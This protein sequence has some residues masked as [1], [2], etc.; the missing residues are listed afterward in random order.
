MPASSLFPA[1]LGFRPR[2]LS[3]S[4]VLEHHAGSTENLPRPFS[5][6]RSGMDLP[7]CSNLSPF[8]ATLNHR[9]LDTV[10]TSRVIARCTQDIRS[11]DGPFANTL[12]MFLDF[13]TYLI[14]RIIGVLVVAPAFVLPT[15]FVSIFGVVCAQVYI[16]GQRSVKSQQLHLLGLMTMELTSIARGTK[17]CSLT[18]PGTFWRCYRRTRYVIH[19]SIWIY[20][21]RA[22][23]SNPASLRAYGIQG[24]FLKESYK[25]IDKYTR[26]SRNFNNF[27]RYA[28]LRH[29]TAH[30]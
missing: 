28:A 14:F 2:V 20:V 1:L 30:I 17:Q 23:N 3:S 19:P 8:L 26:C 9:W 15:I 5:E 29:L 21:D 24:A 16:K 7:L 25:H 6:P 12:L 18:C 22:S 27:N 4:V 10:P 13:C 11:V